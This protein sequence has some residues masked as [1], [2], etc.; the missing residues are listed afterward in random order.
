[1]PL[2][3]QPPM[4]NQLTPLP[5]AKPQTPKTPRLQPK[6]PPQKPTK[7][8]SPLVPQRTP[9][10]RKLLPS[11]SSSTPWPSKEDSKTKATTKSL[12]LKRNTTRKAKTIKTLLE[13]LEKFREMA[14]SFTTPQCQSNISFQASPVRPLLPKLTQQLQSRR[15]K[16]ANQLPHKVHQNKIQKTPIKRKP[17]PEKPSKKLLPINKLL[18]QEAIKMSPLPKKNSGIKPRTKRMTSVST[19]E[20]KL[21]VVSTTE[22][23]TKDGQHPPLCKGKPQMRAERSSKLTS[24]RPQ[25]LL[26]LKTLKRTPEPLK[27]P[28]WITKT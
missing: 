11:R 16:R 18:N 2:K 1:M 25:L 19:E 12:P 15:R 6:P 14:D 5:K 28:K 24:K 10:V 23:V 3:P 4:P 20:F 13:L 9:T 8:R 22:R 17:L 27:L 21:T 7:T 26:K